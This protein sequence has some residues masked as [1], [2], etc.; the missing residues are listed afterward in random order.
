M[1]DALLHP[2][3]PLESYVRDAFALPPSLS[4]SAAH[5]LLTRSA[6]HCWFGHPRLNPLWQPDASEAADIGTIAHALLLERD[7][8]RI[9]VVDADD[10]RTKDA[11][12]KRDAA[13]AAG[14]VPVLAHRMAAIESMAGVATEALQRSPS[15]SGVVWDGTVAEH[16]LVWRDGETWC[17]S[18]P[19]LMTA[20]HSVVVDYKTVSRTAEPDAWGRGP[21]YGSGHDLQAAFALAGLRA[22][23]VEQ[24][25][26]VFLVQEIEP[27][28]ACSLVSLAPAFLAWAEEKRKHAVKV[29]AECLASSH[30]PSYPSRICYAEP[31]AW[32]VGTWN[33]RLTMSGANEGDEGV[34][35][36]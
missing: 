15:L 24:A 28:Y 17:R 3:I 5:T 34:D 36:L 2:S 12:A 31:P 32:A 4:A 20:D 23:G 8:S 19:D 29:W 9:V 11:R 16:T 18:R 22:L 35:A 14:K 26:F 6:H 13:R 25:T 33:E 10:W 27:P 1:T 30:W 7:G 21:L